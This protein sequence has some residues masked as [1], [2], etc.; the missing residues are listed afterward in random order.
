MRRS[1]IKDWWYS[2][3]YYNNIKIIL[4]AKKAD[5][6]VVDHKNR[7]IYGEGLE[8]SYFFSTAKHL[9]ADT[10]YK[11]PYVEQCRLEALMI[12]N[13]TAIQEMILAKTP[14][15]K[16]GSIQQLVLPQLQLVCKKIAPT[17][18]CTSATDFAK[19]VKWLLKA[20]ELSKL[21][22]LV[23][24]NEAVGESGA[25]EV[26]LPVAMEVVGDAE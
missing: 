13:W 12:E 10:K 2:T 20:K 25:E 14:R 21:R 19:G 23:E 15:F 7:N 1:E 26:V 3:K 22:A 16:G 17:R 24:A 9:G 4:Q 18:Q 6:V 11:L 8:N 5:C